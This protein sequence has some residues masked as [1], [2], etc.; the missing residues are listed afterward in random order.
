MLVE[1][2]P[3]TRAGVGYTE[4]YRSTDL[5]FTET[6]V[7]NRVW[8]RNCLKFSEAFSSADINARPHGAQDTRLAKRIRERTRDRVFTRVMKGRASS[9]TIRARL[10]PSLRVAHDLL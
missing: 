9:H 4:D 6:S 1:P 2:V 10:S 3:H 7:K 8:R 5:V